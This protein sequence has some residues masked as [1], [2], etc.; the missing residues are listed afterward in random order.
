MDELRAVGVIERAA[1]LEQ[2]GAQL[3]PAVDFIFLLLA[4]SVEGR[5]FDKFHYQERHFGGALEYVVKLNNVLVGEMAIGGGFFAQLGDEG[6]V[7]REMRLEEFERHGVA[8]AFIA[9]EPYAASAAGG[10]HPTQRVAA[11]ADELAGNQFG[12][13]RCLGRL[14]RG[15]VTGKFYLRIAFLP[16]YL[17]RKRGGGTQRYANQLSISRQVAHQEAFG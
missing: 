6:G 12:R 7:L 11:G 10:K 9:R 17:R 4:Q 2:D 5:A 15:G 14:R 8:E 16:I 13:R 1:K 3:G